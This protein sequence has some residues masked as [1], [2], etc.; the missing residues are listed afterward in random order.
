MA[1]VRAEIP[2]TTVRFLCSADVPGVLRKLRALVF[3]SR[4]LGLFGVYLYLAHNSL[5]AAGVEATSEAEVH[6]DIRASPA[7]NSLSTTAI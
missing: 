3:R 6:H 4:A 1:A 7:N 5:N 2:R